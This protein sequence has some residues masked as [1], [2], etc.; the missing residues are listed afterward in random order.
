MQ[1]YILA[2]T[3]IVMRMW[4]FDDDLSLLNLAWRS[5]IDSQNVCIR[6]HQVMP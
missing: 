4:S 3:Y 6:Y 1:M 5:E 2:M